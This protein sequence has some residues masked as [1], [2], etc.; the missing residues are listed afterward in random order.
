[1]FLKPAQIIQKLKDKGYLLEGF[2]VA[3]FGCG[4]GYFT[5]LFASVV[6]PEGRVK[7][8]DVQ[9]EVL[10]EAKEFI[11]HTGY[12]NIDYILADLEKGTS[13]EDSSIDLVFI[14]QVLFQSEQPKSILQEAYRVLKPG[15]YLVVIEPEKEH[16][17]FQRQ[18]T[19]E[20]DE[21]EDLIVES[22]FQIRE[23]DLVDQF[24]FVIA[25]K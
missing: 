15:K 5:A 2:V 20:K 6:G 4:S 22:G 21:L 16:I 19:F 10:R 7:A 18:K 9:E 17:L 11:S 24:H 25:Q 1:M 12:Q 23:V 3:D 8:I 13:L 14:S